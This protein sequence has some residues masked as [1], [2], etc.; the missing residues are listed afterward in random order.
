MH[1]ECD[2]TYDL[3]TTSSL[4][5][6]LSIADIMHVLHLYVVSRVSGCEILLLTL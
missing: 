1:P 6:T 2:A 3:E 5:L 4:T